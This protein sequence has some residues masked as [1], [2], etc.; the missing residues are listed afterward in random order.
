MKHLKHMNKICTVVNIVY[1]L[2]II[3]HTLTIVIYIYFDLQCLNTC[4]LVF[5]PLKNDKT[6][7]GLPILRIKEAGC[8]IRS[9]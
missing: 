7:L 6:S 2:L 3:Y 1:I 5:G 4:T 8:R 9:N